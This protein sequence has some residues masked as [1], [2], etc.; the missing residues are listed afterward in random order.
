MPA[1][2]GSPDI[3]MLVHQGVNAVVLETLDDSVH[4]VEVGL[5]VLAPDRFNTGPVDTETDYDP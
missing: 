1:D 4:D 2:L 3:L 5:I